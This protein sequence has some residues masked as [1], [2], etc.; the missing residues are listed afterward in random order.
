MKTKILH[1]IFD[2]FGYKLFS[3][4]LAVIIW[5]IIQGEQVL[6][7]QREI[8]VH[9]QV[10]DDYEIRGERVRGVPAIIKGPRVLMLEAPVSLDATIKVPPLNGRNVR[11]RVDKENIRRWNERLKLTILDPYLYVYVDKKVSRTVPIKD[12]IQGIPADGFFIKKV[13]MKPKFV[14]ITGLKSDVLKTREV[15]MEPVDIEGINSNRVQESN[16]IPPIGFTHQDLSPDKTLVTVELDEKR[17]NKRIE[18]IPIEIMGASGRVTVKPSFASV[19]VQALPSVLNALDQKDFKAVIEVTDMKPGRYDMDVRVTI[20]Q[21]AV[22][23][24]AIPAKASVTILG[25]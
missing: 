11:I 5:S 19:V 17:E 4:F 20:P 8:K 9:L 10:P 23:I 25:R 7:E 13:T 1:L 15:A 18:N 14:K 12:V 2:N 16:L 6:E 24:E 21:G 3:L 22:L